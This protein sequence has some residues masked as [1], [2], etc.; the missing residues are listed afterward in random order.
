MNRRVFIQS[1]AAGSG[2]V[3]AATG[4][5]TIGLGL[6]N[7]GLKSYKPVDAI[8]FVAEVGYDSFELCLMPGWPTEPAKLSATDRREIRAALA[9]EGMPMPS[10]LEGIGI[11]GDQ[12]ANLERIR[13]GMQA[14]HDCSAGA[15]GVTPCLQTH[16]GGSDKDWEAKKNLIADR[17]GEW[18]KVGAEMK[19]VLAFKGHNLNMPDTS[20]K[21]LWLVKQVNSPWVRIIYDYSHYQAS[22]ETLGDSLGRL[23]PYIDVISIKDG[24]NYPDKPGY[25]RLLPGDGTIDY[26]DYYRRL[27]KGGYR[28]H[29]V[30][31]VSAQIQGAPGYD[32][33]YAAKHSYEKVAPVMA[34]AGVVR[35]RRRKS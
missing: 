34:K 18:G 9:G 29:T 26:L 25:Q 22:G 33:V 15:G 7:Y 19:M 13:R 1:V 3:W 28:R 16:L 24:K 27:V 31:E 8:K 32:P 4:P 21:A 2:A 10:M 11:L 35:P 14:G 6:G 23:L 30:V 17:L 12:R 20:D 5:A